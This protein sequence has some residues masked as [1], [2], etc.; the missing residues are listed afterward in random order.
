MAA[1]WQLRA[2]LRRSAIDPIE[3]INTRSR[4]AESASPQSFS[5]MKFRMMVKY[6]GMRQSAMAHRF[7]GVRTKR[8]AS[9]QSNRMSTLLAL[10]FWLLFCGKPFLPSAVTG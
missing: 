4:L 10:T 7:A 8:A 5:D 2:A 6:A 9:G 1:E 3:L